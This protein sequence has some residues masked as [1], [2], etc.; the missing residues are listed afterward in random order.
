MNIDL[1]FTTLNIDWKHD[2]SCIGFS[3]RRVDQ[4]LIDVKKERFAPMEL[5]MLRL[6][7]I[8]HVLIGKLLV[9]VIQVKFGRGSCLVLVLICLAV[10]N[11]TLLTNII[12]L[13][14]LCEQAHGA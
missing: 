9:L 5:L 11:I 2:V 3:E 6:Q 14:N 7:E 13:F 4:S 12:A 8:V 1:A 10:S